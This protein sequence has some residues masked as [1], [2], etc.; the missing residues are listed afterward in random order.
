M[1]IERIGLKHHGDAALER[2][3]AG[4]ILAVDLDAAAARLLEAGEHPQ[5]CRLSAARRT[6]E[7]DELAVLDLEI[8]SLDHLGIT[9]ALGD[10][11]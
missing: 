10:G 5:Q 3:H 7:D 6:D 8:H 1:R 4:D 11:A 2:Q 9:E